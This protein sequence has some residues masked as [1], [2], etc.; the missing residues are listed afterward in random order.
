M[1]MVSWLSGL[2]PKV[3]DEFVS[4]LGRVSSVYLIEYGVYREGFRPMC[5]C[6]GHPS[7]VVSSDR[8]KTLGP[9]AQLI[10]IGES[11]FG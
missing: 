3:F 8:G 5:R 9:E 10:W 6:I 1:N 4:M 7:L 11:A 2:K